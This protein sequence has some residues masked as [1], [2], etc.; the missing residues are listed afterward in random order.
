MIAYPLREEPFV[1]S[2]WPEGLDRDL[3]EERRHHV[4]EMILARALPL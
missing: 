4:V 3:L 1:T 2:I